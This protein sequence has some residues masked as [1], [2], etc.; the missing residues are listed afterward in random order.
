MIKVLKAGLYSSIQ[1]N[2]RF[3]YRN[4]GVPHSGV[5]DT[6]SSGLANAL[7]NNQEN[8]AVLEIMLQGPTLEFTKTTAIV[9]S[10]AHMSPKLNDESILN[11]KVY[12]VKSGD[13]LSFGQLIKGLITYVAILGGF[14]TETI[15]NSKS[16][17]QGITGES[18]L[19]KNDCIP[20]KT[21]T[22][23]IKKANS[24]IKINKQFFETKIIEAY[25]GPDFEL[26][27]LAEQ[28]K[29]STFLYTVSKDIN[30]MGYR[31]EESVVPHKKSIITGPVLPGTVQLL[32]SGQ[33]IILMKD[34]QTTGGYP[35]VFQ[36]SEK[37]IAIL[38]Q[39]KVGDTLNLLVLANS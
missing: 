4:I 30:R 24:I 39:K 19:K 1:D 16:F 32:P 14:Q 22:T 25:K 11:Y 20:Y 15:L 33:L 23:S 18:K 34:A 28:K 12:T 36:L 10:G 29:L 21:Q 27:S 8:D 17:Y 7:L 2:G 6:I 31:L 37:S 9:I 3:G 35:R 13:I 38:A 26:F 5:M